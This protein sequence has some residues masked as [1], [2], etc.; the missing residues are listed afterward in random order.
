M[1]T[2]PRARTVEPWKGGMVAKRMHRTR[3]VA[4]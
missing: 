4:R 3:K 2:G 1:V